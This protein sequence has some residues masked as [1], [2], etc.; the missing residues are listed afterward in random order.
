[1]QGSVSV[2]LN[3]KAKAITLSARVTLLRESTE[4]RSLFILL[5]EK[6]NSI[7]IKCKEVV[8]GRQRDRETERKRER[9][10]EKT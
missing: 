9:E 7:G 2:P 3:R 6:E 4:S 1:M 10:K 5:P 8:L